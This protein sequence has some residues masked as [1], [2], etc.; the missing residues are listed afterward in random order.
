MSD[1]TS[2]LR[3]H[4]NYDKHNRYAAE[5]M[6]KAADEIER[7][8]ELIPVA[9]EAREVAACFYRL[10]NC[11]QIDLALTELDR[12]GIKPDFGTRLQKAIS[13]A[14]QGGKP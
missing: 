7:L 12:M 4:A 9:K 11:D 3:E 10:L 14:E 2:D 13:A 1:L 5:C 6:C 8:R